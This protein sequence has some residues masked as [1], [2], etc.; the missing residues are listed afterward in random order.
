MTTH[1]DSEESYINFNTPPLREWSS[2]N[3]VEFWFK[4]DDFDLYR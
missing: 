3:T 2:E 1:L 4:V